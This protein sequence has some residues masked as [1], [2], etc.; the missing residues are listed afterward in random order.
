MSETPQ[1][2]GRLL[3]IAAWSVER[4]VATLMIVVAVAVF[5]YISYERLPVNLMP[6][7]S[8]PTLTVRTE[9]V[10]AAPEEVEENVTR[11]L[12]EIV[13]TV[14]GV[15]G[16]SSTSRA[17]QSDIVLRFAW[18][19][20][21]DFAT[22]KVRERVE[23]VPLPEDAE[24]PLLLRY[25]PALDPFMRIGV[26]GRASL[27]ELRRL[28]EFEIQR[29]LEKVEGVAMIKVRG[30][31]EE[32][33]RVDLSPGRMGQLG[34]T[35]DQVA[36]RLAAENV[37]LAGGALSEGDVTYLVRTL[38]AFED[39]G[40]IRDLIVA[41]PDGTPV[42]L[43]QVSNVYR[44]VRDREVITRIGSDGLVSESVVVEVF[45]EADANM[46]QV[47]EK[48]RAALYGSD[49]ALEKRA[50]KL[51]RD[52]AGSISSR[53][54][55]VSLGERGIASSAPMSKSDIV[56]DQLP[57]GVKLNILSDQATFIRKSID[58][59]ASTAFW[60]GVFAVLVLFLFLRNAWS[61]II[62]ALS[63]PLSVVAA[64]GALR[65]AGVT[66]NVM[67]LGGIALGIGMLVDNSIVVLESIFRCREEGDSV[68]NSALRGTREVAGAVVAS[69]LTTIA[70]F[71]PI[72]F[73]EGIAGQIFGDLALSVVFALVASLVVAVFFVPMLAARE[74]RWSR[75][76]IGVDDLRRLVF[77]PVEAPAAA[78][79]DARSFQRSIQESS[80]ISKAW[81]V[82]LA[83]V[84]FLFLL[85]RA[86]VLGVLELV[87]GRILV[88]V[89]G[90]AL[91]L[92]VG[93]TKLVFTVVGPIGRGFF[94]VFDGA[95]GLLADR[96]EP[97]LKGA[98]S[99][100][101]LVIIVSLALFATSVWQFERLGSELL[102]TMHQGEYNV[103]VR[104]PVGTRLEETADVMG[105][106]ERQLIGVDEI[107][108]F[109]TTIGVERTNIQVSD[110]GEHTARVAVRIVPSDDLEATEQ[111]AIEA[112][113]EAAATLPGA[114]YE[115]R[116]PEL[117]ALQ[118]P[119]VVEILGDDLRL[120]RIVGDEVLAKLQSMSELADVRTNLTSGFPEVQVIFDRD[121]LAAYDLTARQVGESIRDQIR[122]VEPTAIREGE[123]EL[124]ILVRT[125]PEDVPDVESLANLIVKPAVDGQ[126]AIVLDTV[127]NLEVSVGPS[128]IRRVEGGRAAVLEAEVPLTSLSAAATEVQDM[129]EALD[130][131]PGIATR[132]AGQTV[133][134]QTARESL[135]FA[136]LLAI[137]LVYI[138]LASKFESFRGPFVILLSIPL[139]LV[140]VVAALTLFEV[141]VS[142]LVFIGMIMLTGI[143]VNNAIV[144]VDYINQLRDR[145]QSLREAVVNACSIR[146]RPV[147]ITTLTTVLGLLPMALGLGE[148]AE[149]RKPMAITVIAGLTSSTLLTLVVVPVLYVIMMPK[150][151]AKKPAEPAE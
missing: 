61:T 116:R 119:L 18:D 102:P 141:R 44:D 148:G 114:Q 9:L 136:L 71:L 51:A 107:D 115:I 109:S 113:R 6:E 122:G 139:A 138:V 35:T 30:G 108:R 28:S 76:E 95:Y 73:V 125:N 92:V 96:Y 80:S 66:L 100:R 123:D 7:L 68:H 91:G 65:L 10:G 16:I 42:R 46:V 89:L 120:L 15:V 128:E 87:F 130:P 82:L 135:F 110:E 78:L 137:F 60:G 52:R 105:K 4:P 64:F 149:L 90:L 72:V 55:L 31:L 40:E 129:L 99:A 63:I 77:R 140:G 121:R 75:A 101:F 94:K 62:I 36:Q 3:S 47:S 34:V 23:L 37:N 14:E 93:L 81:R 48:V 70:V 69:T 74:P 144:L 2:H 143:V 21:M 150:D 24:T 117:F 132:I 59:V 67:S 118:T 79:N 98:I 43:G 111:R 33:I 88:G 57:S 84:V 85:A 58:E 53:A 25:D 13:R 147:L 27:S 39:I 50:R 145:G 142:V 26:S 8:Y 104:M 1:E 12:E 11:R 133:E 41:Y 83:P 112:T 86:I 127:A 146:L 45:K 17:G 20:D 19:T 97:A 56:V 124:E 54:V 29:A 126:P 131:P 22:Q 32:V 134:M 106:L 49:E 5:G 103:L 38:N 151:S